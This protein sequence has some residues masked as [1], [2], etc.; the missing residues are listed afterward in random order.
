VKRGL[1]N[2]Q[3]KTSQKPKE[4]S[5]NSNQKTKRKDA[6][7]RKVHATSRTTQTDRHPS[8]RHYPTAQQIVS[9]VTRHVT[10]HHTPSHI[11]S[12]A[13]TP[14]RHTRGRSI[15]VSCVEP[16]VRRGKRVCVLWCVRSVGRLVGCPVRRLFVRL[17]AVF[18]GGVLSDLLPSGVTVIVRVCICS[19]D[20]F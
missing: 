12:D 10:S 2:N 20:R 6:H 4:T 18:L 13:R 14:H 1:D 11:S 8:R 15:V 3:T 19:F 5:K 7:K 17:F 16:D 9:D